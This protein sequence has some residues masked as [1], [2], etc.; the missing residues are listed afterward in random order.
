LSHNSEREKCLV[1]VVV[2]E[3]KSAHYENTLDAGELNE[4]GHISFTSTCARIENHS[5]FKINHV[6]ILQ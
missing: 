1:F 5:N 3:N 4:C 2:V 6:L